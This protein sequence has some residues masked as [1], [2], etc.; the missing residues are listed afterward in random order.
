MYRLYG[1]VC[2]GYELWTL[3]PR[4]KSLEGGASLGERGSGVGGWGAVGREAEE[5]RGERGL[6]WQ[7]SAA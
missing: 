5:R 7:R 3:Q 2:S 4:P 1:A 6:K